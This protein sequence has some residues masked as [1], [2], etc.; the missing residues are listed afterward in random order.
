MRAKSHK[1]LRIVTTD[2]FLLIPDYQ[3]LNNANG[4]AFLQPEIGFTQQHP[5][6][7]MSERDGRSE[8]HHF[9][10]LPVLFNTL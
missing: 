1:T 7:H 6:I 5:L 9:P 3:I 2:L 4:G 10:T 8:T